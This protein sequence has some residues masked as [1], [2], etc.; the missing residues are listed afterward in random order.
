VSFGCHLIQTFSTIVA[1]L[2]TQKPFPFLWAQFSGTV[3]SSQRRRCGE[4]C[5]L[6]STKVIGYPLLRSARRSKEATSSYQ[7]RCHQPGSIEHVLKDAPNLCLPFCETIRFIHHFEKSHQLALSVSGFNLS[8]KLLLPLALQS[9]TCFQ[10]WAKPPTDL[11]CLW[12][13]TCLQA[14]GSTV[15]GMDFSFFG[16]PLVVYLALCRF[17]HVKLAPFKVGGIS[18]GANFSTVISHLH[19]DKKLSPPL[20]GIFLSTPAYISPSVLPLKYRDVYLS[21]EHNQNANMGLFESKFSKSP[22]ATYSLRTSWP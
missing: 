12:L 9:L 11:G 6:V 7:M 10:K 1:K 20:S 22:D 21:R 3:L 16:T 4:E 17:S 13:Q 19:R 5:F 18:A 8:C 15:A 14:H 2:S